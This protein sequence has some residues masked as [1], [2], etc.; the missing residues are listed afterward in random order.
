MLYVYITKA[1][2][3][4]K[5]I[6]YIKKGEWLEFQFPL[7]PF[8]CSVTL[9][10]LSFL[11]TEKEPNSE[12]LPYAA[13]DLSFQRAQCSPCLSPGWA[14]ASQVDFT[15]LH[16]D[17]CISLSPE[18]PPSTQMDLMTSFTSCLGLQVLTEPRR[19]SFSSLWTHSLSCI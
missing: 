15:S 4:K 16:H 1:R 11:E 6:I 7:Y 10:R 3:N 18:G 9:G 13:S 2:K 14:S 5:I 17:I 8:T 12:C 19:A